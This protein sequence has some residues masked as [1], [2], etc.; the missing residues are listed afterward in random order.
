MDTENY[1]Q[2]RGW[3]TENRPWWR[4]PVHGNEHSKGNALFMQ[5]ERDAEQ[6]D[7]LSAQVAAMEGAIKAQTAVIE[8]MRAENRL[9]GHITD[10]TTQWLL[11]VK[12]QVEAALLTATEGNQYTSEVS[13]D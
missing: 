13:N 6:F 1:L 9:H 5:L 8:D 2:R 7:S 10:A 11:K 12:P 3:T 4:D